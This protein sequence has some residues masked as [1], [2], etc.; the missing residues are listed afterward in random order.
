MSLP[1]DPGGFGRAARPVLE[2]AGAHEVEVLASGSVSGLTRYANS[3]IV[4]NT[5][6]REVRAQVRVALGTRVASATTNQVDPGSLRRAG[7]RALAAARASREDPE[8]PGMPDP[9]EAG[10]ARAVMRYDD[11]TAGAGPAR[12]AELAARLIGACAG[13]VS[14]GIVETGAHAYALL[15]S[16]GVARFDAFTRANA[17][18]LAEIDGATGWAERSVVALEGLDAGE[19]GARAAAR[20]AAARG[21]AAARPGEY[22]VVLA[23]SAVAGL[24]GYLAY[25]GFGAKGVIEGE[26]FLARRAGQKV[27][28]EA[29]TIADDVSHEASIGIGFD[30]EGCAKQRVAVIER[31]VA[32][33]PVTDRRTARRLGLPDTGHSSGSAA[34]GPHAFN[35]VLYGGRG[36]VEDLIAAVDDGIFVTRFW[37]INVLDRPAVL[38]TGMTRDGTFR[39]RHGELA[40]PLR[41][42]RFTQGVLEALAGV[43]A[44]AA[45]VECAVPEWEPLGSVAAPAAR[46][47]PFAFSAGPD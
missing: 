14:A 1:L 15:N 2:L 8:Y 41:N 46:L 9:A 29:V 13:A 11:A 38:F 10:E 28:A 23:P 43:G 3:G 45:A 32:T 31:G 22:E 44:L 18:C 37:Y 12:R 35:T 34:W 39:I 26:S 21:P 36:S 30:L 16:H 4:Q 7:E 25:A 42:L 19:L 5:V 47:A 17:T 40:E 20:A 33:G 27:A 24:I 6:R